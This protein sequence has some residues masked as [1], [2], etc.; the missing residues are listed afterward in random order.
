M[1]IY[2]INGIRYK[3]FNAT[4]GSVFLQSPA[5]IPEFQES[6]AL[7]KYHLKAFEEVLMIREHVLMDREVK[8]KY[9]KRI[10]SLVSKCVGGKLKGPE[11]VIETRDGLEVKL[12]PT[13]ESK[14]KQPEK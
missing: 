7:C 10:I 1:T 11:I 8:H 12:T 13:K 4:T 5:Q 6:L 3:Q 9:S 2:K 14:T